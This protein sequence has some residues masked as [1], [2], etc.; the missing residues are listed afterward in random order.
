MKQEEDN[1]KTQNLE[2]SFYIFE[3]IQNI[4]KLPALS[5]KDLLRDEKG[6]LYEDVDERIL[7]FMLLVNKNKKMWKSDISETLRKLD[8]FDSII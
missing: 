3:Q 4:K 6:K 7:Q 2:D 1:Q 5:E 8:L